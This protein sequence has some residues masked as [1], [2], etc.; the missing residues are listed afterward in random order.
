MGG[1]INMGVISDF[2]DGITDSIKDFMTDAVESSLKTAVDLIGVGLG[3]YSDDNGLISQYLY[4]QPTNFTGGGTTTIWSTIRIVCQN[5]VV[6][7]GASLATI[8]L[9]YEFISMISESNSFKHFDTSVFIRWIIKCLV[10]I[11]LVSNVFYLASGIFSLGTKVVTDSSDTLNSLLHTTFEGGIDIGDDHSIGELAVLWLCSGIVMISI[12]IL[13]AVIIVV[14]CSRMIEI[15][16][17][18]GISPIPMATF[19]NKEWSQIGHNWLRGLFALA[20]Q[21]LFIVFAI[22]IYSTLLMNVISSLSDGSNAFMQMAMLIGYS[23]ALIFTI[24]R[25]GSISKSIFNAH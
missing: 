12:L 13:L 20:F 1:K 6:P 16:M 9:L 23:V 4:T 18:F 3:D 2:V 11:L 5:A 21:G 19:P 17:Y 8:V 10:V 15:M 22:A 14:L 25:T 7:I 24:L